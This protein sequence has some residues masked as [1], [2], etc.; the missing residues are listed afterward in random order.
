MADL[1]GAGLCLDCGARPNQPAGAPCPA[2]A[3]RRIIRHPELDLLHIAHVDCDAFYAS[4][5]KRDDPS[6]AEKPV[7]VG[8]GVRGVVTTACYIARTFGVR[9]AMPMFKALKACPDAVVVK[10][11][12]AKYA[13]AAREVRDIMETLT[14]LVEPVSIDEAFLDLSGTERL[15]RKTPAQSLVLLQRAVKREVGITVSIGLSCNK[16]LAKTASD[17]DKPNGFSVIGAAEA[18]SVLA[19]LSVSAIYGVGAVFANRLNMDGLKT[20]GDLQKAD[21]SA[22]AK[23]YGDIGLR[24]ADLSHGR[25]RRA[26]SASRDTKSVSAE[27]TFNVDIRDIAELEAVLWRL[28]ERAASR[29]KAKQ[30]AGR[31][32]TLKLKTPDF[33]TIT[34]RVTLPHSSNLARTLFDAARPLLAENARGRAFRLIGIG[35]SDLEPASDAAHADL[36]AVGEDRLRREEQ[37]IDAIRRKF[38]DGAIALGRSQNWRDYAK[39]RPDRI[40]VEDGDAD[41]PD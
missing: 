8:G 31:V 7:I 24:L 36:F 2:C 40:K 25:D 39:K 28:S 4:I 23:R 33:R 16:F 5:E 18:A 11:N 15:H 41:E 21:R 37:A 29:M 22:L 20:I 6:I 10:P 26:V 9:S 1:A 17:F 30:L 34:R 12:F 13:L 27:T 3:S 32:V 38:G 35:Y 14:P 19:P